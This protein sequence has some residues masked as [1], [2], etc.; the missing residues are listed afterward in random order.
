MTGLESNGYY[1]NNEIWIGLPAY[2]G[3]DYFTVRIE[4]LSNNKISTHRIYPSPNGTARFNISPILKSL[5]GNG[6]V[7]T[8][9]VS[10]TLSTNNATITLQKQFIKGGERTTKTNINAISNTY[11]TPSLKF[12]VFNGYPITFNYLD[13]NYSILEIPQMDMP[14][15]LI[16]N[17]YTRGCNGIYLRFVNQMGGY[18]YWFFESHSFLY[19]SDNLGGFIRDNKPDDLGNEE[20]TQIKCFSKF[21][22]EYINLANDLKVS[23]DISYYQGGEFI[24]IRNS[25]NSIEID[26]TKRAYSVTFKF[27]IDYRFNPSLLWS[28]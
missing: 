3:N 2:A 23:Q 13:G 27:D 19:S 5:F 12:P 18:S 16:E 24:R 22:K 26:N 4:N 15:S 28:N 20:T 17:K 21:P 1:I 7:N 25:K 11:L 6:T 9:K 10:R 14:S 8:F